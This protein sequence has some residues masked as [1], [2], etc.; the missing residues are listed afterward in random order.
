MKNFLKII[1]LFFVNNLILISFL[2]HIIMTTI[3]EQRYIGIHSVT[4]LYFSE[5]S[6]TAL[7]VIVRNST[8]NHMAVHP[9]MMLLRMTI[10]LHNIFILGATSK[11]ICIKILCATQ[12]FELVLSCLYRVYWNWWALPSGFHYYEGLSKIY[13][14]QI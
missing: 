3:C 9:K 11:I 2:I 14:F 12:N 5:M 1:N 8:T 4:A 6:P 7:K 13:T 10:H